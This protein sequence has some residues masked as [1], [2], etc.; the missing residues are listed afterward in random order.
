M[1]IVATFFDRRTRVSQK[2]LDAL[3]SDERLRGK[4]FQTVIRINTTIAESAYF[5]QP[6]VFYRRS[7]TGAQDYLALAEEVLNPA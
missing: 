5:N 7:S 4:V 2:I 1:G 3:A 6:V